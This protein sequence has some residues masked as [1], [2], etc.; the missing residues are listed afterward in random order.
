[1]NRSLSVGP[2]CPARR[3]LPVVDAL[4]AATALAHGLAVATRNVKDFADTG[5]PVVDPFG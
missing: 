2:R 3:T 4:I 5:V 1:M